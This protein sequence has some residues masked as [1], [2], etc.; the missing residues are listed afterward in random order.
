MKKTVATGLLAG[1]GALAAAAVI[2]SAGP[3]TAT[4]EGVATAP[5]PFITCGH[6]TYENSDGN[7][8]P[9]PTPP[10]PSQPDTSPPGATAKCRD[11]DWSFS[12]HRSGTCSGHGGVA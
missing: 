10:D 3:A 7:C 12:K 2:G 9:D 4:A 8:V 11:G 5:L 6:G 1:L